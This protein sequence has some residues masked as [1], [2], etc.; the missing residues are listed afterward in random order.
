M[1]LLALLLSLSLLA[2]PQSSP[3]QQSLPG[4]Q[5]IKFGWDKQ[6]V[7]WE[8]DPFQ[9]PIESH[10]DMQRQTNTRR[11]S[12][13]RTVDADATIKLHQKAPARV[14]F[15]YKLTLKN[16]GTKTIKSVDWDYLFFDAPGGQVIGVHQFTSEEQIR[17]GK[18]KQLMVTTEQPPAQ[19]VSADKAADKE[20]RSATGQ[21]IIR[22][23][24]YE[25]GS[26]W[27]LQ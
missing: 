16:A 1:S 26:T 3:P 25:D 17:P 18:S 5:V 24:Q 14:A 8:R 4:V 11:E 6:I 22:R 10:Q 13:R 15:R 19:V 9:R 27:E 23:I 20:L 2:P 21:V 7:G 12:P